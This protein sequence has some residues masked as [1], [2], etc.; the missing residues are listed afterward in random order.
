MLINLKANQIG[1]LL[2]LFCAIIYSESPL[3]I[4]YQGVLLTDLKGNPRPDG[5]YLISFE[6]F[7][8]SSGGSSLWSKTK[9]LVLNKGVF[10]IIFGPEALRSLPTSQQYWLSVCYNWKALYPR[11][12][13]TGVSNFIRAD[14]AN[15]TISTNKLENANA[16][17]HNKLVEI[18]QEQQ[19]EIDSLI[20]RIL[21]LDKFMKSYRA[22]KKY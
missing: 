14:T 6:I 9:Q 11:Y 22:R 1:I 13:L 10:K 17:S 2:L 12:P 8:Y 7:P 18:I 19:K 20:T 3:L 5:K 15:V 4:A 21:I 16:A